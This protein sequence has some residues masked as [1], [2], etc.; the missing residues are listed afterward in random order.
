MSWAVDMNEVEAM[1]AGTENLDAVVRAVARERAIRATMAETGESREIVAEMADAMI[2][3]D[4]EAVLDLMD[5]EPTTLKAG[6]ARYVQGLE[7]LPESY[8]LTVQE[9][10]DNLG[11]LS[12]YPWP[13]ESV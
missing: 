1:L 2:S 8:D 11:T 6:L 12:A 5:G 4:H 13:G 3:M 9:V 7:T 10:V